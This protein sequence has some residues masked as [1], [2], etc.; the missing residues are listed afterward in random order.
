MFVAE[1]E[2]SASFT[3]RAMS[4]LLFRESLSTFL[5]SSTKSEDEDGP[6]GPSSFPDA[7]AALEARDELAL[8]DPF[9]SL[10]NGFPHQSVP[11]RSRSA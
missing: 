9:P 5:I 4:L 11:L 6:L 10:G 3:V 2:P 8:E 1:D 7:V